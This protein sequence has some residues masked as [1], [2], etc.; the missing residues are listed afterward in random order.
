M[1]GVFSFEAVLKIKDRLYHEESNCFP[2]SLG[3]SKQFWV[4]TSLHE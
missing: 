2:Y 1:I 3:N 4:T